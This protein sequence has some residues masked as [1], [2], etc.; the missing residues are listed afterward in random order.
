VNG[1]VFASKK[2]ASR[3]MELLLLQRAGEIKELELQVKFSIDINGVHICN[4]FAD[5]RYKPRRGDA[6]IEDV[7]GMRTPVYNLKKKLMLA[8]HG[9]T[10]WET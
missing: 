2:E 5:F 1:V 7:K 8:C 3:Y 4:Y 10:I 9:I 6:V